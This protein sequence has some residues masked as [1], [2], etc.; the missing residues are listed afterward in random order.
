V[1][2]A[3]HCLS[4]SKAT[5]LTH[6]ATQVFGEELLMNDLTLVQ[7]AEQ[8]YSSLTS[9]TPQSDTHV[10]VLVVEYKAM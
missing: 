7:V 10:Y 4:V 3:P 6:S 8:I 5:W 9:C 2:V 1:H